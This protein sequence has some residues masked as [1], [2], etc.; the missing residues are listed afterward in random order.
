MSTIFYIQHKEGIP[1]GLGA[2]QLDPSDIAIDIDQAL[3]FYNGVEILDDWRVEGDVFY[4]RGMLL[5]GGSRE[6]ISIA[7]SD[8]VPTQEDF[9]VSLN[10]NAQ[11]IDMFFDPTHTAQLSDKTFELCVDDKPIDI[12]FND[13]VNGH[14][15]LFVNFDIDSTLTISDMFRRVVV[16]DNYFTLQYRSIHDK[17]LYVREHE[18]YWLL[19]QHLYHAKAYYSDPL[20][21]NVIVKSDFVA[22]QVKPIPGLRVV[23]RGYELQPH[24]N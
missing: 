23:V 2:E 3:P 14:Y 20:K 16:R 7:I 9:I 12:S 1:I 6:P 11:A 5:I 17:V 10:V 15:R 24:C 13:F 18:G 21:P 22:T 19:P 8:I 4:K